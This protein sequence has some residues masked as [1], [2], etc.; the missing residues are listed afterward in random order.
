[1]KYKRCHLIH[2][3][4][5]GAAARSQ[6]VSLHD[7]NVALIAETAD[8]LGITR[9]K[10]W[11]D[12]KRELSP[13]QVRKIYEVVG[14]LWPPGTDATAALPQ[15]NSSLRALYM[16][17]VTPRALMR[18]VSRFGLYADQILIFNP[19]R[20]PHTFSDEYN[21]V[22]HP[23]PW[24]PD[25]LKLAFFLVFL[26]PWVGA[27]IVELIPSPFDYDGQVREFAM[28]SAEERYTHPEYAAIL[29]DTSAVQ[30]MV[31]EDWERAFFRTPLGRIASDLRAKGKSED[32]IKDFLEYVERRRREDPLFLDQP[33]GPHGELLGQR[34]GA[35]LE[36]G[37]YVARLTGAF[38]YTNL[39][40]RWTELMLSKDEPPESAQMWTPLSKAFDSLE[41]D[42]LNDV[43]PE[44][45]VRLRQDGRLSS[46]RT[47]LRRVW[48]SVQT[49]TDQR[50]MEGA[51][52][53]FADELIDE[54]RK[55][56]AEWQ[57]ITNATAKGV[58]MT[59]GV[60]IVAGGFE[61]QFAIPGYGITLVAQLLA[62]RANRRSFRDRV[63]M[64][65]FV[66]LE[67]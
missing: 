66:D 19:F 32:E 3:E 53:G 5:V 9:G 39:K 4:H 64:S 35:N 42:F 2:D 57:D 49:E 23:E 25:T 16:G 24:L 50:R 18:N 56:K 41:F 52:K 11:D 65:V 21:P 27:G 38:P 55:A 60:A 48:R 63:P 59:T 22:V 13:D 40:G 67:R 15:P 34:S 7:R 28:R 51:A 54:H 31:R 37:L 10:N 44:F 26:A 47:F 14:Q 45:A 62:D 43:P 36:T 33:P 12:I 46:F 30:A 29:E 20:S 6:D 1:M 58:A 8:I 61:P 17:D